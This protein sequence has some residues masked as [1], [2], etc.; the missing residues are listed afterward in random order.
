MPLQLSVREASSD[1]AV[2]L[3]WQPPLEGA[4]DIRQYIVERRK[5][6]KR[7]WQRVVNDISGTCCTVTGLAGGGEYQFRVAAVN[8]AGVGPFATTTLDNRG[9]SAA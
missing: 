7:A 2:T 8:D 1:E 6:G 9:E 4:T 5:A 3:E